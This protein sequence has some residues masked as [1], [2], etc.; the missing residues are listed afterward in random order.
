MNQ[1]LTAINA[2]IVKGSK[3]E[4]PMEQTGSCFREHTYNYGYRLVF[5]YDEN[6]KKVTVR[7][8]EG[9]SVYFPPFTASILGF[10]DNV[11]LEKTTTASVASDL[12]AG[13]H[14]MFVYSD[15]SSRVLV[16][17]AFAPVLRTLPIRGLYGD[18]ISENFDNVHYVPVAS[19]EFENVE[20]DLS[21]STGESVPFQSG[22]A[23]CKLH[24]TK[25]NDL[26]LL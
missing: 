11:V 24:F 1:L 4:P 9:A 23:I 26:N 18:A 19:N 17:D 2:D 8:T 6:T 13:R 5:S 25:Y 20:I 22:K 3:P 7:I 14:T 21:F 10:Q 16:G 12:S 15:I